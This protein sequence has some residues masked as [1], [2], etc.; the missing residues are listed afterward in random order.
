VDLTPAWFRELELVGAYASRGAD[1]PDA[2][3]LAHAPALAGYV[4]A[5]YPLSRWR[6]AIGHAAAAGRLGTVKVA[7]APNRD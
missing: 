1:F 7:F 6:D 3:T 5:V 2:L 4:D